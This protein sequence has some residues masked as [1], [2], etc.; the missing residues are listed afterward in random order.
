MTDE[1]QKALLRLQKTLEAV[2]QDPHHPTALEALENAAYEA[3][4][5]MADEGLA[6]R[7]ER[8]E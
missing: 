3:N 4:H 1:A 2:M 7:K 8:P 5:R 6:D